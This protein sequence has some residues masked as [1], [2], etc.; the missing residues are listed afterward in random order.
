MTSTEFTDPAR[1]VRAAIARLSVALDAIEDPDTETAAGRPVAVEVLEHLEKA[2]YRVE[3]AQREIAKAH[4]ATNDRDAW[5]Q[6]ADAVGQTPNEA[7]AR[8]R[9]SAWLGR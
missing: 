1:L 3:I 7:R 9:D 2:H 8:F 4:T 6:V 5:A